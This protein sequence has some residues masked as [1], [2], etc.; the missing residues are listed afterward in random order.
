MAEVLALLAGVLNRTR[1][2]WLFP[3]RTH[4]DTILDALE[5]NP[6]TS[7]RLF[8]NTAEQVTLS[9]RVN[10]QLAIRYC[11][12][13][14]EGFVHQLCF[15]DIRVERC[16]VHGCPLLARCP[17]CNGFLDPL[18]PSAWTCADCG[19]PLVRAGSRWLEVF[20][21]GRG[22]YVQERKFAVSRRDRPVWGEYVDRQ[23][24]THYLYEEHAALSAALLGPHLDCVEGEQQDAAMATSARIFFHCPLA[25]SSVFLAHQIGFEAQCNQ[26]AWIPPKA[27]RTNALTTVMA[28]LATVPAEQHRLAVR[29]TVQRWLFEVLEAVS[30]AAETGQQS[31]VWVATPV[32]WLTTDVSLNPV[33]AEA[34]FTD[35]A[36][37]AGSFCPTLSRR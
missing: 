31:A 15:Q 3:C 5:L 8:A 10:W 1:E 20:K 33:L 22:G 16:P 26:G 23:E 19:M 6:E 2:A 7:G 9:E 17:A 14:L 11:P 30:S 18:C 28:M 29:G 27:I 32:P 24:V 21:T 25:A 13:C 34:R 4:A 37:R 12:K 35:V 36:R